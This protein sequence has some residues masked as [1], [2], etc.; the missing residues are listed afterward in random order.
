MAGGSVALTRTGGD[1][2]GGF[3]VSSAIVTLVTWGVLRPLFVCGVLARVVLLGV[4][5]CT[6]LSL[7]ERAALLPGVTLLAFVLL[8]DDFGDLAS[9]LELPV[10]FSGKRPLRLPDDPANVHH[11]SVNRPRIRLHSN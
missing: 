7:F 1:G 8:L 10:C 5:R 9:I 6:A 3:G 2:D 11:I 4:R